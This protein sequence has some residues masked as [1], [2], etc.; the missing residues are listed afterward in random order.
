MKLNHDSDVII[1]RPP[2][3]LGEHGDERGDELVVVVD[4]AAV[5][6]AV[7]PPLLLLLADPWKPRAGNLNLL[8]RNATLV[9][10]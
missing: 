1:S 5:V 10:R 9:T 4:A 2:S 8:S 6:D 3:L 7:L